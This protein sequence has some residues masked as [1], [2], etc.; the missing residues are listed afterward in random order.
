MA[1]TLTSIRGKTSLRDQ[2]SPEEWQTRVD[3]A[4][5]HR[6]AEVEGWQ[7]PYT[8]FNHL[9]ARVP[10]EPD[11][12][13]IKPHELLFGE[14]TASNLLKIPITGKPVGFEANVNPAGWSIHSAVFMARPDVNA[15]MH[16]HSRPG[17]ALSALKDGLMYLNQEAMRFYNRIGYH[18]FEGIAAP[19]ERERLA[20]D[21]GS[22]YALILRNHGVLTCN[23]DVASAALDLSIIMRC[24]DAQLQI[25]ATGREVVQPPH[26]VCEGAAQLYARSKERP[27]SWNAVKRYIDSRKPGYDE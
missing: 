26:E 24:A 25:L 12:M 23:R 20:R 4:A 1:P 15:A 2:V 21:L 3:L 14:V 9:T 27:A 13:L 6:L 10:G 5:A 8:I 22:H 18:E 17:M 16:V 11:M 19:D 7:E